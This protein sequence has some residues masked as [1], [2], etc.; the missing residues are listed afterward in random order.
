MQKHAYQLLVLTLILLFP[1]TMFSTPQSSDDVK[2]TG[3]FKPDTVKKGRVTQGSILVE[4]PA[5]LHLQSNKPLDKFL[6]ATKL[7][8]E[9]PTGMKVGPVMYP[10]AVIRQLKF[11]KSPVSVYEGKVLIRFNVT[12]P[13]NYAGQSGDVRGKLRFQ[14]CNDDSCFPPVT[15]EVKIGLNVE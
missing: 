7:D 6:V 15:R 11:S 1:A 14:A 10:R 9:T 4:I 5:G 8:V 12:V 2:T 3:S 13:S